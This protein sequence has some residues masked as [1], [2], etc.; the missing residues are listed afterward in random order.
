MSEPTATRCPDCDSAITEVRELGLVRR[1]GEDSD[2][3]AYM[4][5]VQHAITCPW[6]HANA[7]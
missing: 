1:P 4:L 3:A 2:D 5:T 7:E 6:Y